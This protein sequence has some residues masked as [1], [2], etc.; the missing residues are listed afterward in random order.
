M[1]MANYYTKFVGSLVACAAAILCALPSPCAHADAAD[2][3]NATVS[4][5][6]LYDDNLFRV[7]SGT[8]LS[9]RYTPKYDTVHTLGVT[10]S[11]DKT[12]SRQKLHADIT[13]RDNRYQEHHFLDNRP[14]NASASW[15]WQLGDTLD[16][17]LKHANTRS[18]SSFENYQS[19]MKDV[20]R[21]RTDSASARYRF[22]PDWYVEGFAKSYS[23]THSQLTTSDVDIHETRLSV[24]TQRPSGDRAQVRLI[25]REGTYPNHGGGVDYKYSE[26]QVDASMRLVL[27]GASSVSGSFGHL[28]R[29][30]PS[31]PDRDFSGQIASLAW[32]WLA[33]AKLSLTAS[34]ERS[35]G[36]NEDILSTYALTDTLHLG[37]TWAA[38][39]KITLQA[40]IDRWRS[41]YRGNF[42]LPSW[43]PRRHD[44]G[45]RLSFGANYQIMR[46]LV[47]SAQLTSSRRDSNYADLGIPYY[48]GQPYR[49]KTA[50]LSVQYS[51]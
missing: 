14:Y 6:V 46:N 48:S 3:F 10:G 37:A 41:D 34:Y 24:T 38:T 2:V 50:W 28:Q 31:A 25:R 42:E 4:Y 9:S 43:L 26:R 47:A 44:N 17:V 33:T 7:S 15:L 23:A 8:T 35:L 19:F 20:Y 39:D 21:T 18:I 12:L 16:G 49:D 5:S 11:I 1:K 32:D 30:N 29:H 27:S 22:H 40:G 13:V 45:R 36:V 51:F